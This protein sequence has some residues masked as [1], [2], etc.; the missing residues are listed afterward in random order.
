MQIEYSTVTAGAY[1]PTEAVRK[2]NSLDEYKRMIVDITT[3][4][5]LMVN[6]IM[7]ARWWFK[8]NTHVLLLDCNGTG[9]MLAACNM[10]K[11]SINVNYALIQSS[12][13]RYWVVVNKA[14]KFS[15]L[16]KLANQIPGVDPKF[17]QKSKAFGRFFLRATPLMGKR[18]LFEDPTGLTDPAILHWYLEFEKL[19]NLPQVEQ[20]YRAEV[21]K[22]RVK[23]GS[24]FGFAA[25]PGFQL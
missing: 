6:S 5:L 13:S 9:E 22:A 12:P 3:N 7:V 15:E 25:N 1:Q 10:L 4:R 14:G 2:V 11:T 23:D 17:L 24:I 20:R 19:W 21:L 18:A 8:N 16:I